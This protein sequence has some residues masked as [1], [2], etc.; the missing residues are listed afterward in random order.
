MY[1]IAKGNRRQRYIAFIV[2]N[3]DK[4]LN[5]SLILDEIRK[6]C[7]QMLKKDLKETGIRLIRFVDSTGIIKC[8]HLEKEN[9]ILILKSI[10]KLGAKNVEVVPIATSG[11]IRSLIKKHMLKNNELS[12]Y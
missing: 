9:T 2:K 4:N 11:T 1:T 3:F 5:K 10:K 8:N 7:N 12:R 6:K